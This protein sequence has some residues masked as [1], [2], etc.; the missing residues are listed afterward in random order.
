VGSFAANG[1]GLSD[2]AGNVWEWCADWYRP[3]LYSLRAGESLVTNPP[4][5]SQS[6]DAREPYAPKRV[7]RGGSFLCNDSYCSAYRPSAR[8]G[9]SPDTGM[10]HVG[11]RCVMSIGKSE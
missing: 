3:D 1:F 4:G 6:F 8:R 9:N 2:M 11:F 5:P 10:S 7:L